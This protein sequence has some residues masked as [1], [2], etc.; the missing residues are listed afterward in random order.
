MAGICGREHF[1]KCAF[2]R[3]AIL[4]IGQRLQVSKGTEVFP[5]AAGSAPKNHCGKQGLSKTRHAVLLPCV[6]NASSSCWLWWHVALCFSLEREITWQLFISKEWLPYNLPS[7]TEMTHGCSREPEVDPSQFGWINLV[8]LPQI[9]EKEGR[10]HRM[11][12]EEAL[13]V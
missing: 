7:D 9:F 5:G 4:T 6:V 3:Q 11:R 12:F 2:G 13:A 1:G 8:S 10:L